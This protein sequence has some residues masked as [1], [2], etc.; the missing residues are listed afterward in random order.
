QYLP[1]RDMETITNAMNFS[2]QDLHVVGG[3][4]IYTTKAAGGDKKLYKYI[5]KNLEDQYESL[6]RLSKSLS[7]PAA[8]RTRDA[9]SPS[10]DL[11]RASPF[12]PLDDVSARRTFAYLVA[13]LNANYEDY[14]FSLVAQPLDFRRERNLTHL[15]QFIDNQLATLRPKATPMS[16]LLAPP[17]YAASA[18]SYN[19][20]GNVLWSPMMWDLID[21]EMDLKR[22]ERYSYQPETDPLGPEGAIWNMHYFFF[23]KKNK[24]VCYFRLRVFSLMSHSPIMSAPIYSMH[25]SKSQRYD[26]SVSYIGDGAGKRAN[27]WLGT[28]SSTADYDAYDD[29]VED[30]E[31]VMDESADEEDEVDIDGNDDIEAARLRIAQGDCSEYDDSYGAATT[32]YDDNAY[33]D[34]E[35]WSAKPRGVSEEVEEQMDL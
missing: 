28:R 23:N 16:S 10:I 1:I 26:S 2:T 18:P 29:D 24:R 13:T 34:F 6:V 27:Y 9:Q 11:S 15:K 32:T 19:T 14:D 3:C 20:Q 25:K 8:N 30:D 7:P 35:D 31:M 12:G 5:D 4:D 22:C 33:M 21:R 17:A